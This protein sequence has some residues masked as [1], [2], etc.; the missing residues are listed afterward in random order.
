M[1]FKF[2]ISNLFSKILIFPRKIGLTPAKRFLLA[3]FRLAGNS[4]HLCHA[5]IFILILDGFDYLA[6]E[7]ETF[8]LAL[9]LNVEG[10][11]YI[12]YQIFVTVKYYAK[13]AN[14]INFGPWTSLSYNWGFKVRVSL[15]RT[16]KLWKGDF[17]GRLM[18][19]EN[20]RGKISMLWS[21]LTTI[22]DDYDNWWLWF[23][24]AE[25]TQ[26]ELLSNL[27]F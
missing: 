4:H 24:S 6:E 11:E 19:V 23:S 26:L 2:L 1:V 13:K 3:R 18:V 25:E 15:L 21:I 16:D 27:D 12:F 10:N 14:R 5:T 9:L 22:I 8:T 17:F 20:L 7:N